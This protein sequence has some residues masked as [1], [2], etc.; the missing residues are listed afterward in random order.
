MLELRRL[1]GPWRLVLL[2]AC[3]VACGDA[4]DE[5]VTDDD[6]LE[7]AGASIT[8]AQTSFGDI[9]V[10]AHFTN[11]LSV[12]DGRDYAILDEVIRLLDATPGGAT[13][14]GNVFSISVP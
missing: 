1:R 7:S 9:P 2:A 6:E 4:T 13:V 14:R 12:P 11:P 3:L 5:D 8:V 10:W